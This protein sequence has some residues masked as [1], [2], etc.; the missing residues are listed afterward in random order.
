M[1]EKCVKNKLIKLY[2]MN[3][4]NLKRSNN[5]LIPFIANKE[6]LLI[7]YKKVKQ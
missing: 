3:K 1:I 7:C 6:L 2:K 4:K 5:N